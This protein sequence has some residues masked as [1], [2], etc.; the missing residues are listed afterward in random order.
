MNICFLKITLFITFESTSGGANMKWMN[1]LFKIFPQNQLFSTESE[2]EKHSK[3]ESSHVAVQ[4]DIVFYPTTT[5]D[6]KACID[7]ARAHSIPIT[8]YGAGSG[9]DGQAI[10]VKK[11]IS[12]N[13]DRM[14][15]IVAFNPED[16]T[17][18]I[19]PGIRRIEFNKFL[20]KHGLFFPIDPGADAS[21]GGMVATNASGTTAVKY[22][23]MRE[24]VLDLEVVL[25][26]GRIIHTGSRAKKSSSG[27]HLSG[28]FVGSEG[29]LGII[30]EITLKLYGIPEFIAA[31][32]ATF[33][34]ITEAA[35]T[36]HTILSYGLVPTRMELID[37]ESIRQIN[38]Y[39]DYMFPE[40][41][42]LF[43]EFSGST[44]E[45]VSKEIE[46][47]KSISEEFGVIDWEFS[48]LAAERNQIWK[49]RHEISYAY[50]HQSRIS[51]LSTDVCVPIS[52]LPK[53]IEYA[54]SWLSESGLN[55]GV[56][57][58][59][60]DGNFHTLIVYNQDKVD[61]CNTAN[62]LYERIVRKALE[63]GGTCTGEHGVG[64]GKM[65]YQKLEHGEA[66]T[67]M[68]QIKLLFD[69]NNLLNPGKILVES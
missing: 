57:G 49:A 23:S 4:P 33:P 13:F 29:T 40:R 32:K 61:E 8:P 9:L 51:V 36:T 45:G 39:G 14:N 17:I 20:N 2:L 15:S 30:S 24:Q 38:S 48:D 31:V 26:D 42:T 25:A 53:L 37:G 50:R 28:L 68:Q 27:Y 34:S 55:G 62:L 65:K 54:R 43:I 18:T 52:K 6:I 67:S 7:L 64:L 5:E 46:I 22:G 56:F 16:L 59:V 19:Q 60:G 21:I 63:W 35:Q 3:D 47:I 58:H 12:M 69:P 44:F 66:F 1:E 41:P 11:G 10:P